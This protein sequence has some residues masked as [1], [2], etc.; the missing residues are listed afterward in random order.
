LNVPNTYTC[1]E[2]LSDQLDVD[3]F[4]AIEGS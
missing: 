2:I 3:T 1:Y 4:S